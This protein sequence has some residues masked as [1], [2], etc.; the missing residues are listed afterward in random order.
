MTAP[1]APPFIHA[2]ETWH[3]QS[4]MHV[5]ISQLPIQIRLC[6]QW[7]IMKWYIKWPLINVDACALPQILWLHKGIYIGWV[8]LILTCN[9][10]GFTSKPKS[11]FS[12][13]LS[14]LMNKMPSH[15]ITHPS[16]LGPVNKEFPI[17]YPPKKVPK[18]EFDE[19]IWWVLSS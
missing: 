15:T 19:D 3:D 4:L 11:K 1:L 18:F 7:R 9:R 6:S 17:Y 2:R 14:L 5:R 16:Y 10:R 13:L 12:S 8:S